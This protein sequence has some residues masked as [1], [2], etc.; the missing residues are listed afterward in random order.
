MRYAEMDSIWAL[1]NVMMAI[2]KTKT[3][4]HLIARSKEATDAGEAQPP[5]KTC[6]KKY[7]RYQVM[8]KSKQIHKLIQKKG[9]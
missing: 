6:V 2:V 5:K 1:I 7:C 9:H 8:L 3:V 4:A